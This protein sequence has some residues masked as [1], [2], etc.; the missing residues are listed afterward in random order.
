VN[1]HQWPARCRRELGRL[2]EGQSAWALPA[3]ASEEERL[4]AADEP[5]PQHQGLIAVR[6]WQWETADWLSAA[7]RRAG[8]ATVWAR[9]PHAARIEG[10]AAAIFDT[11]DCQD[12]EFR[13]LQ[14]FC[15]EMAPAPVLALLGF[16]RIADCRQALAAG[17]AAVLSKPL[18]VADLD[19][20]LERLAA[21]RRIVGDASA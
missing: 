13:E 2:V 4:L 19:A 11:F 6:A 15:T 9:P 18:L 21:D 1:W 5:P 10:A 20:E 17:A 3:T 16:P 12:R 8:W 7:C 14:R